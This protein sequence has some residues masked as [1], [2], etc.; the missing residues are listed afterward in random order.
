FDGRLSWQRNAPGSKKSFLPPKLLGGDGGFESVARKVPKLSERHP[1]SVGVPDNP[2]IKTTREAVP[3]TFSCTPHRTPG[4]RRY[5]RRRRLPAL[6]YCVAHS[7]V[8]E[9]SFLLFAFREEPLW[10]PTHPRI[11]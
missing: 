1:D 8:R 11:E 4:R 2:P 9:F 10:C 6:F 7:S 3:R 5:H